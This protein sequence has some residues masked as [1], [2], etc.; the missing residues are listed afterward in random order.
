ML[1]GFVLVRVRDRV[2][3]M[4]SVAPARWGLA[5]A[6]FELKH[7]GDLVAVGLL[8]VATRFWLVN[9]DLLCCRFAPLGRWALWCKTPLGH[10][11]ENAVWPIRNRGLSAA[12]R[13]KLCIRTDIQHTGFIIVVTPAGCPGYLN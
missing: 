6:N 2:I 10:K 11:Y 9:T 7:T 4:S 12:A 3:N 5:E 13:A 1:N 8:S